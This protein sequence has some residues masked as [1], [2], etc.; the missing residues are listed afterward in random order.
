[1]P[2]K[3][4][5]PMDERLA[6]IVACQQGEASMAEV[7]RQ[8]GISRKTGYK[9]WQRYQADG[10]SGLSAR[11]R[12]PHTHPQAVAAAV[13]ERLRAARAAHPTWGPRK[14]AAWLTAREP[15][16]ALPAAST[17]GVVLARAGLVA[18][19]RRHRHASPSLVGLTPYSAANRVWCVDFKG[20][21]RLGDG[22]LCYPLTI[23]DGAS[24]YLLRCQGL[25]AIDT[26]RVQPLFVAT[27]R[28][29]GLPETIRSDNGPPFASTGL[30]GLSRLAVWWLKLGIRPERIA[31]G[32]PGQNGR[33]ERL[34]RTLAQETA[35]PPKAS[36]RAQQRA[37][38]AFRTEYNQ[39]RP[40]EALGQVP[41]A[42]VYQ[43]SSRAYPRRLI[44]FRYPEAEAVRQVRHNGELQWRGAFIYVSAA[45][46]GERV[47]LHQLPDGH[48]ELIFGPLTLGVLDERLSK[49]RPLRAAT[50]PERNA[51]D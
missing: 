15:D 32:K 43:P 38:D 41:P 16:L 45:L 21:F 14:L 36:L 17:I 31:P 2:W 46:A 48:W 44:R 8:F 10:P 4:T 42:Q 13:E 1:M 33:H 39:E 37:F 49:I 35:Q 19:R 11:S 28:E 27:F 40:H 12:A 20:Q 3:E 26:A 18:P 29:F 47:G 34:H 22:Q 25:P 6:F 50:H 5:G 51:E 9:W 7:C 23:S 30:G 24:R